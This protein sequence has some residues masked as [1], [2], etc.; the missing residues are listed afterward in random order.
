MRINANFIVE[1]LVSSVAEMDKPRLVVLEHVDAVFLVLGVAHERLV[2]YVAHT[3]L[4]Y[5]FAVCIYA[6]FR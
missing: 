2:K 5:I 4:W 1:L 6:D 3:L